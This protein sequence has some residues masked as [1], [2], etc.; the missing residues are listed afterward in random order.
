M[1]KIVERSVKWH[2]RTLKLNQIPKEGLEYAFCSKDYV[3]IHQFVWCKDYMQDVIHA[4]MTGCYASIYGFQY[5]PETDPPLD[6]ERTRILLN[7]Y[8]DHDFES[9]IFGALSDFVH[10]IEAELNMGPTVFE[11][12][13]NPH[14]RYRKSG[15]FIADGDKR[16]M[17]APPMISLYTLMLRVGM[18]HTEGTPFRETIEKMKK[19]EIPSYFHDKENYDSNGDGY[20]LSQADQGINRILKHGDQQIFGSKL[21]QNFPKQDHRGN[22]MSVFSIHDSFGMVGFSGSRTKVNFP[23]WHRDEVATC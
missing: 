19:G 5:N 7:S 20:V 12:A 10:Q 21:E 18:M 4:T 11:K 1:T 15:V 8:K 2:P 9:K 14:P 13:A 22:P 16:W 6:L 17:A 23:D 3:Q